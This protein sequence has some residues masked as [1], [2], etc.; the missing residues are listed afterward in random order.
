MVLAAGLGLRMRPL[1]ERLP[2]PLVPVAGKALIDRLLDRLDAAGIETA[3]V[4]VHYKA[5]QLE[6]HL[7]GRRRPRIVISDERAEL[8]ETGGGI[9]KALPHLGREAFLVCNSDSLTAG[10]ASDSLR[11]LF[12]AWDG[13]RMDGLL[14][15]SAISASLGYDGLGDFAMAQDG[16]IRR[17]REKEVVP[18]V[19]TGFSMLHPRLLEGTPDGPFSLNAPWSRAIE[20]GRLFGLR[21]DGFWM[22]IGDPGALAA[23]EKVMSGGDPRF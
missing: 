12:E 5:D 23:A 7:A 11:R 8:L 2:K 22:H 4:N 20:S 9:K 1:T 14:L 6:R 18:F 16:T 10:G 21:Q 13:E 15:L 3:V 19:Y 17:R